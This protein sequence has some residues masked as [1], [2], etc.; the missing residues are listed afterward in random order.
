MLFFCCKWRNEQVK[1]K[2]F[3]KQ[4]VIKQPDPVLPL[5]IGHISFF[6]VTVRW[7]QI[8]A[9]RVPPPSCRCPRPPWRQRSL[10]RGKTKKWVAGDTHYCHLAKIMRISWILSH[11]SSMHQLNLMCFPICFPNRPKQVVCKCE[12]EENNIFG[13]YTNKSQNWFLCWYLDNL[14]H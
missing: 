1:V 6:P 8:S 9:W 7:M 5:L 11:F 3:F 14:S 12:V 4:F 13:L 10:S 2:S